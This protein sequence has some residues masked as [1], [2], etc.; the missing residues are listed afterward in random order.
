MQSSES[1]DLSDGDTVTLSLSYVSY[2]DNGTEIKERLDDSDIFF[3][4]TEK[5]YTI[6]RN[7]PLTAIQQKKISTS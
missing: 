6:K 5:S 3:T 4:E 1:R 7:T 2:Y